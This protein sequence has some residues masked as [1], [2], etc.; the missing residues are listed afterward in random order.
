MIIDSKTDDL[1]IFNHL[2]YDFNT[3]DLEYQRDLG[4]NQKI[5]LPKNYYPNDDIGMQPLNVWKPFAFLLFANWVN[6]L[7]QKTPY[8]LSILKNR[9]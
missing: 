9:V 1:F 6:Q 4:A 7:Y 2:E 5:N 3:L 8:D